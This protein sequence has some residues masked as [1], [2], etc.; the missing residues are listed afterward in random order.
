MKCYENKY[1]S[2]SLSKLFSRFVSK[3]PKK[4]ISNM[5][6]IEASEARLLFISDVHKGTRNRADDFR[7]SERAYNSMLA[8]YNRLGYTLVMLGDIEE[9]WEESPSRVTS[10]YR[11]TFE[12]E[13]QF[14]QNGRLIRLHGNHDD[15]WR[16]KALVEKYFGRKLGFLRNGECLRVHESFLF[17][18]V[19]KGKKLGSIFAVH[20]H[21]G[22][23]SSDRFAFFSKLFVRLF[24]P[25][26]QILTGHS[27][28]PK[29]PS[30]DYSLR[31]K[32]NQAL[33]AWAEEQDGLILIAG[34]THRPVFSSR[35]HLHEVEDAI[36]LHLEETPDDSAG[37]AALEAKREWIL[38]QE[39]EDAESGPA[40]EMKR[41]CYFNTGC[42]CFT[43]GD[44]TAIEVS[45]GRIRLIH[46]PDAENRPLGQELRSDNLAEIFEK[47]RGGNSGN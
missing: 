45:E 19:D 21:Q 25:A 43:D 14:F 13:M 46:W 24:S 6:T 47:L 20:G 1:V 22:S 3:K 2:E 32:N 11:H 29:T 44:V 26:F 36:R 17:Q 12:L 41:P 5:I 37:L 38:A 31:K 42:C 9:L 33:Y 28:N 16:R 15:A 34:H 18:V 8:Y 4:P 10:K 39:F 27:W 23:A 40:V 35:T 30:S 7:F